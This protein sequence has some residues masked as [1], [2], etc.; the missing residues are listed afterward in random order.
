[1]EMAFKIV[2][3]RGLLVAL[4]LHTS[5][6]AP[7]DEWEKA[8]IEL[9]AHKRRTPDFMQRVR[10]LAISDGAA[11][12]QTQR[13]R[14]F[15]GVFEKMPVKSSVITIVLTSRIKRGIATAITWLNPSFKA[16]DPSQLEAS[17]AHVDLAGETSLLDDFA[18]LQ[19]VIG[20]P[21]ET[22][23]LLRNAGTGG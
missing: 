2:E 22:L 3:R 20:K 7:N 11:P 6:D 12:T 14:L 17:L 4:W 18:D 23:T 15:S 9:E 8:C 13:A 5:N 10:S 19:R 21:L 1:M 16:F